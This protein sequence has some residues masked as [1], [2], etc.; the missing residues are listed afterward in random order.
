M[1]AGRLGDPEAARAEMRHG[2]GEAHRTGVR[3][4]VGHITG[5]LAE[6]EAEARERTSALHRSTQGWSSRARRENII[7]DSRSSIAF[8][9]TSC[10]SAIPQIPLRAEE[11]YLGPPS[12]SRE[13][14]ARAASVCKP[15]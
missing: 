2:L 3:V 5:I 1:G 12:P 13:S 14:R 8:A 10:S 7:A 6:L 4:N 9:A 11:A 15:R